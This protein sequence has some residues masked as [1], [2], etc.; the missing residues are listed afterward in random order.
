MRRTVTLPY[1][2]GD[3]GVHADDRCDPCVRRRQPDGELPGSR[4]LGDKAA[5][6][7][8]AAFIIEDAAAKGVSPGA[9]YRIFAQEHLGSIDAC[10][11]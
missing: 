11:E 1:R 10:F 8:D 9:E 7:E 2:G 4:R 6:A 5:R 3:P